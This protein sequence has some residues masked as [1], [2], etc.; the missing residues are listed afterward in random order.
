MET[1][2]YRQGTDCPLSEGRGEGELEE[3]SQRT[4]MHVC[5]ARGH[6]QPCGEGRAVRVEG[7]REGHMGA[8]VIVST[9]KQR[10]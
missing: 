7:D 5:I 2:A 9:I 4:H 8:P 3:I 6:K 1:K 10:L